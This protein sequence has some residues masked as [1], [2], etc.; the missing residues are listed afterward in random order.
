[1]AAAETSATKAAETSV[2]SSETS[3]EAT[4]VAASETEDRLGIGFSAPLANVVTISAITYTASTEEAAATSMTRDEARL[5]LWL[6]LS[7]GQREE[8]SRDGAN[9]DLRQEG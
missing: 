9:D 6:G 4:T 3:A 7:A 5:S 2:A 8:D 1:M